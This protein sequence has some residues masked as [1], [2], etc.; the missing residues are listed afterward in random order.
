MMETNQWTLA[1]VILMVGIAGLYSLY[2]G[3]EIATGV[4]LGALAGIL[5]PSG[6]FKG[7]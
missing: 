3:N 4:C 7:K 2:L 5:V 6:R 1:L